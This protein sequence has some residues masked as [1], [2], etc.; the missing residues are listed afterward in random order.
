MTWMLHRSPNQ[1]VFDYRRQIAELAH[2]T[3]SRAAMTSLAE[4]YVG[5]PLE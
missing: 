1:T 5:L 2:V 3:S 4:S